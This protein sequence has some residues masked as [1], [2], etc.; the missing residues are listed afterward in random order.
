MTS[1]GGKTPGTAHNVAAA[2]E[3]TVTKISQILRR[4]RIVCMPRMTTSGP[5]A[6]PS[7]IQA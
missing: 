5:S 4:V 7:P 6:V 2:A 3:A 1:K